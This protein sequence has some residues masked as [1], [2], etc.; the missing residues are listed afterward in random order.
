MG[1]SIEKYRFFKW[2][3]FYWLRIPHQWIAVAKHWDRSVQK[4]HT[5]ETQFV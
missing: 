1:S 4:H 3:R 5:V 2:L